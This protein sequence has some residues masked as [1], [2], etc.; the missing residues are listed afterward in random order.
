MSWDRILADE[1]CGLVFWE[2]ICCEECSVSA[3]AEM[4]AFMRSG[5]LK[6]DKSTPGRLFCLS[7]MLS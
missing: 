4:R 5:G 6:P 3:R 2:G 1:S 7:K